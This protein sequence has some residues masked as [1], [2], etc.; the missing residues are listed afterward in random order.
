ML[1]MMGLIILNVGLVI[2]A[3][4]KSNDGILYR[5]PFAVRIIK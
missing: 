3:A 5:Y 1:L 2:M 4:I